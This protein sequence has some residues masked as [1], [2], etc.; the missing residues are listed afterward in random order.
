[1]VTKLIREA[2]ESHKSNIANKLKTGSLSS[3]DWWRTLKSVISPGSKHTLPPLVRNGISVTDDTDKTNILND[4]FRDQT[5]INDNGVDLPDINPYDVQSQL[6]SLVITP[7]E[8]Q[9]VL[10]SLH[11]GKAAGPDG[12]SNRVLR[13]LCNELSIPL[14]R[15]FNCS[16]QTGVF[17]DNWKL[18]NVTPI[19]KG[20]DRS[21]PSNYRPVS[22]LCNPEKVF[23]RVVFKHIYNHLNDN[24]ILT[25]LQS[26]FIAGD[27]TINQLT[28]LYNFFTQALDSGKEVRVVFC[29][30]SKAFD[31]V[32]HEG[33]LLKLE[34]AGI[35]GSL[36]LWFRS[37]L[38]NRKQRVVL[39]GA[40]SDWRYIRTGVPQGSILGPLLFLLFINDIVDEIGCNIRLF[41]DDTSLYITV[42]NPDM[43]AELVNIDLDKIMKWAKKWLVLFNPIKTESF[44]AS[45]K[46]VKPIH[47]P[48]FMEGSQITEVESHKHLGIFLSNDC[49]WHKHIE[50]I[51]EKAWKRVNA[52]R[53]LKYEFDRKSLEIIYFSFIRPILEYGDTIWDNCTQYEKVE[54]DKIQ[55][56]AARIV[57]GCTKLVS[58]RNLYEETKW[59]SL[60]E[61]RKKHKLTLLYKMVNNYTP[62]YLSSLVP[63]PVNAAS[64]YNLRNQN[65]IQSIATRTNYYFNSFLPSTIREWNSIPLDTRNSGSIE[66]FK[67]KLNRDVTYVPKYYFTGN[68]KLQVLHSRLRTN[69]SSLNHD[70]FQRNIND[71]PLC[72]CGGIENAEHFF[73]SC[74]FYNIQRVALINS[75]S[76]HSNFS[77]QTILYGNLMLSFHANIA[78]FEAVQKYIHDTNRF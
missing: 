8:V 4:F 30:I 60:E 1:M 28:Y 2:K 54:L 44:L 59:E 48:L 14:C 34:A 66:T 73:F 42:E 47:P 67:R 65:N 21:S 24:Q 70:L 49:T 7:E 27:S 13:E 69:C 53:K 11:V 56:E 52:M 31:R 36:L 77:L 18:S 64:A 71:S 12:I 22:L 62:S 38:T 37:Y 35:S 19:D 32:W 17:P 15:L 76:V 46:L 75:V 45:R 40:E 29:D 10:K 55:N 20:G 16:L 9:T 63:Q 6:H 5:L 72:Q 39:P 33:L 3:R 74:P 50:Y 51:K 57:T 58:I 68:R 78:I 43:A 26:G 61:R 41:A 23:E 25:P